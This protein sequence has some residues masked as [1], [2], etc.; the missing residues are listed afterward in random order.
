MNTN[1]KKKPAMKR[2]KNLLFG[3][4]VPAGLLIAAEVVRD[5]TREDV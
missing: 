4:A 5:L 3:R 1:E 2:Y